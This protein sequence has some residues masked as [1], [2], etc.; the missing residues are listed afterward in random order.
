MHPTE[1]KL[2]LRR[3]RVLLLSQDSQ[4]LVVGY[5]HYKGEFS[6]ELFECISFFRHQS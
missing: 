1:I 5:L 4:Y 6:H 3:A 2:N